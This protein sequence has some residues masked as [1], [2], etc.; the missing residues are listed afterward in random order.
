M[1]LSIQYRLSWL[2]SGSVFAVGYFT[3]FRRL[4]LELRWTI[5]WHARIPF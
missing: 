5:S 1:Y 3:L 2:A 4:T